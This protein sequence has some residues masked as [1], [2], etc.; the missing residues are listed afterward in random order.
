VVAG[1]VC[2]A[3]GAELPRSTGGRWFLAA[4]ALFWVGRFVEQLVFLRRQ[5]RHPLVA[6]LTVMFALGTLLFSLPLR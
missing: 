6:A 5:L 4:G 2:L 1:A 3:F